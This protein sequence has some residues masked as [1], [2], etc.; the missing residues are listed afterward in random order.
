MRAGCKHFKERI[1]AKKLAV[2]ER[3]RDPPPRAVSLPIFAVPRLAGSKHSSCPGAAEEDKLQQGLLRRC[4]YCDYETAK[5]SNLKAHIRN[6]TDERPFQCPTCSLRFLQNAHLNR[7]LLI[8]TGERPFQCGSCSLSFSQK[9]HLNRHL[10]IHTGDRPYK[11][12]L[13]PK[14]FSHRSSH[15]KSHMRI[16]TGERP[17][18]CT[19][20]SKSFVRPN[21]LTRHVKTVHSDSLE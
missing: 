14:S 21:D 13:C 19:I 12:H 17:Y 11:C 10:R 18:S 20:C 1:L 15:L 9:A 2:S 6:H 4:D 8:H 7:H 5:L 16:H 3:G